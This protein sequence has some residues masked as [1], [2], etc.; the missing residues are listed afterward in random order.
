VAEILQ[1]A[2]KPV[3]SDAEGTVR[4]AEPDRVQRATEKVEAAAKPTAAKPTAAKPTAGRRGAV[5]A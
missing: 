4:L 5:S 2:A 3:G 1:G